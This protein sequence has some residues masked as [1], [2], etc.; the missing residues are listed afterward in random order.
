MIPRGTVNGWYIVLCFAVLGLAASYW[1]RFTQWLMEIRG[2]DWPTIPAT[3]DI[4]S[5]VEHRT[6]DPEGDTVTYLAMLTYFYRNPE[7]QVG[8]YTREF[9]GDQ[10]PDAYVWAESY[11][12]YTVNVH[13][14]P[15]NPSRSV[16]Q[17][18]NINL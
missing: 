14:D 11:K 10:A 3:I 13:V 5:V 17:S 9:K 16:L 8:E 7:L 1:K 18:R 15:R 6:S 2:R 12:G 4:V